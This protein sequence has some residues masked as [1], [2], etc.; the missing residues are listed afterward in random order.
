MG[1]QCHISDGKFVM[2]KTVSLN[3]ITVS[4]TAFSHNLQLWKTV[5]SAKEKKVVGEPSS[6]RGKGQNNIT[7]RNLHFCM[8]CD[9]LCT[10]LNSL[11]KI[12][13]DIFHA[14]SHKD[15]Q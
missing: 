2:S 14:L 11:K 7:K 6:S 10:L 13:T 15:S 12:L 3:A 9:G 5:A 8:K 1:S 4:I